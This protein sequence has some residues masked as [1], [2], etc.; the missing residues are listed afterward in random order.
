MVV[1]NETLTDEHKAS[2]SFP[3]FSIHTQSLLPQ[4]LLSPAPR[5]VLGILS[6]SHCSGPV[7]PALLE[8]SAAIQPMGSV[9]PPVP[10]TQEVPLTHSSPRGGVAHRDL[11][12]G[13]FCCLLRK[14]PEITQQ[15]NIPSASFR[16]ART[17]DWAIFIWAPPFTGMKSQ[18]SGRSHR[19]STRDKP[20]PWVRFL[21]ECRGTSGSSPSSFKAALLATGL[22]RDSWY[23]GPSHR[24]YQV[25]LSGGYNWELMNRQP[26]RPAAPT[27]SPP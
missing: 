7:A 4:H 12:P 23:P 2:S 21:E 10:Q 11:R 13:K 18:S 9:P 17:P 1:E 24:K 20:T 19:P 15:A 3:G 5:S 25:L 14:L 22:H 8:S 27:A 6:N 16:S 26:Q